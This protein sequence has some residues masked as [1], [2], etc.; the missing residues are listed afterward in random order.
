MLN[1]I[2]FPIDNIHKTR[3]T[4]FFKA[5]IWRHLWG[6]EQPKI[7]LKQEIRPPLADNCTGWDL[8]VCTFLPMVLSKLDS[9][10]WQKDMFLL[11]SSF[12]RQSFRLTKWLE[13]YRGKEGATKGMS[14]ELCLKIDQILLAWSISRFSFPLSS[15]SYREF[16]SWPA[17]HSNTE[18]LFTALIK[19]LFAT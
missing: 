3:I 12:T 7:K 2:K 4:Y 5:T 8:H 6:C 19:M 11:T 16:P 18:A 14:F 9:S 17:T 10:G 13:H 15:L 1:Q